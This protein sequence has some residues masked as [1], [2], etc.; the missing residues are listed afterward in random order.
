MF[1]IGLLYNSKKVT[2][3]THEDFKL[4]YF[5]GEVISQSQGTMYL[6]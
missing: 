6:L 3:I 1:R 5:A 4:L 2:C